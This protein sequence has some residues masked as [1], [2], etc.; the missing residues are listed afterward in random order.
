MKHLLKYAILTLA[1]GTSQASMNP[2]GNKPYGP[3]TATKKN[4]IQ[5][6]IPNAPGRVNA[7]GIRIPKP[8]LFS[9][10]PQK[11]SMFADDLDYDSEVDDVITSYRRRDL[12]KVKATATKDDPEG[13]I[14]E[15]IRW[16]LFLARQ[17]A[18]LIHKQ[19]WA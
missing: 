3:V 16:K 11:L 6:A 14:S 17:A 10:K 9:G 5:I 8:K 12:E 19:K 18:M 13:D 7:K 2:I 1:I 15:D 4:L